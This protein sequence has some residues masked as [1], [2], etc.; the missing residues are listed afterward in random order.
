[1]SSEPRA[2]YTSS[3]LFYWYVYNVF[4]VPSSVFSI[5][6]NMVAYISMLFNIFRSELLCVSIF[7][8]H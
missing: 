1:M 3:S 6:Y 7:V 2:I 8:V 4:T 5:S